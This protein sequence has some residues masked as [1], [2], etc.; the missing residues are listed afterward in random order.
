MAPEQIQS[1]IDACNLCAEACEQQL[2]EVTHQPADQKEEIQILVVDCAALCRLT[3]SS[4]LAVSAASGLLTA[5]C[6]Q[7]CRM[8]ASQEGH[9]HSDTSR[10]LIRACLH[11]AGECEHLSNGLPSASALA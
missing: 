6:A 3:A 2:G 5:A 8:C 10:Q 4:L 9:A 11:C 7:V 1:C